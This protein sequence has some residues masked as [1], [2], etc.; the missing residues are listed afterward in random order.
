MKREADVS[1]EAQEDDETVESL[2]ALHDLRLRPLD[3]RVLGLRER[4][5][6]CSKTATLR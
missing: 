3:R 6:D 5:A 1:V 4:V 2:A